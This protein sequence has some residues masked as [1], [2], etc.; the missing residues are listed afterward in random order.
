MEW[1]GYST[2][3][4][5][6]FLDRTIKN[7]KPGE[8][9]DLIFVVCETSE[10]IL[11]N[12]KQWEAPMFVYEKRHIECKVGEELETETQLLSSYK[13]KVLHY[14]RVVRKFSNGKV[15][16]T[17][18]ASPSRGVS[19]NRKAEGNVKTK[20]K[21]VITSNCH[22]KSNIFGKWLLV[23]IPTFIVTLILNQ[24]AYGSC[25]SGYCI[26]AAFP[27]VL[28]LSLI[29]SFLIAVNSE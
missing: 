29:I 17:E 3:Y 6:V 12:H 26:S 22:N 18:T 25:Y 23:F 14:K 7:N 13:N 2:K 28:L 27:K 21:K 11:I 8:R 19:C 10:V 16:D 1:W 5:W 24:S 9:A 15:I 20:P 4:G